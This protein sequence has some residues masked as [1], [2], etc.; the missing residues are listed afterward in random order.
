MNGPQKDIF[1]EAVQFTGEQNTNFAY[2]EEHEL[3]RVKEILQD[4]TC[5]KGNRMQ[6]LNSL[7]TSLKEKISARITQEIAEANTAIGD[8]KVRFCNNDDFKKLPEEK[9]QNLISRFDNIND[10]IAQQTSIAFISDSRRRFEENEYPKLLEELDQNTPALTGLSEEVT[11]SIEAGN[12]AV[13]VRS[14]PAVEYVPLRSLRVSYNGVRISS[15]EEVEAYLQS[16]REAM[17][18]ELRSGKRIRV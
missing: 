15:E 10:G 5:Y 9:R 6:E 8:L 1:E 16:M 7:M 17:L 11:T 13:S 14:E 18:S 3:T 2:I 4:P 12:T